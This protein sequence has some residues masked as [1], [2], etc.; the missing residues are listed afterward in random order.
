MAAGLCRM[1]DTDKNAR[2]GMMK[3]VA[4]IFGI[5][6]VIAAVYFLSLTPGEPE[7]Q[8]PPHAID[9]GSQ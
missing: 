5:A 7:G 9:Q 8:P 3:F 4:I 6:I 2:T 1:R